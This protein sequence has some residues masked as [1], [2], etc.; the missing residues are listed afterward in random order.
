MIK[1][2][3]LAPGRGMDTFPC[4]ADGLCLQNIASSQSV[5]QSSLP[6]SRGAEQAVGSAWRK[7]CAELVQSNTGCIAE[8]KD[9]GGCVGAPHLPDDLLELFGR[10]QVR[11]GENDPRFDRTFIGHYQVAVESSQVE[12]VFTGLHDEGDINVCRNHLGIDCLAWAL[13][14]QECL[15]WN[16]AMNQGGTARGMT[17]NTHP[18]PH[19]RKI[20]CSLNRETELARELRIRLGVLISNEKSAPINGCDARQAVPRLQKIGRPQ[21]KPVVK[22]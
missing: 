14:T 3:Q 18:V 16:H 5:D 2:E 22:S 13:T 19:A 17:L 20:A 11:L 21:L 15:P 8:G 4:P 1:N 10:D 6:N 9:P 12:I 7:Q